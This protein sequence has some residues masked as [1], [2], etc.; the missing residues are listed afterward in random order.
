[1][2]SPVLGPSRV[3]DLPETL[4]APQSDLGPHWGRGV[5]RKRDRAGLVDLSVD[6][7]SSEGELKESQVLASPVQQRIRLVR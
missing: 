2:H 3:I 1:M 6:D 4:L 7:Q 5:S